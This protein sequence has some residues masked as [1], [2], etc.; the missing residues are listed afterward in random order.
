MRPI[1]CRGPFAEQ[2]YAKSEWKNNTES[3]LLSQ[4]TALDKPAHI[5]QRP[6]KRPPISGFRLLLEPKAFQN[7][8]VYVCLKMSF[9]T[10]S[11]GNLQFKAFKPWAQ[12]YLSSLTLQTDGACEVITHTYTIIEQNTNKLK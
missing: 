10:I 3:N 8:R 7:V 4:S 9:C 2:V 11:S 1:H 6:L 12:H 5:S